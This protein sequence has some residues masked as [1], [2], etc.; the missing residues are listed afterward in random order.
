MESDLR[1]EGSKKE[2]FFEDN[3]ASGLGEDFDKIL[4]VTAGGGVEGMKERER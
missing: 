4:E 3:N 2:T 1:T